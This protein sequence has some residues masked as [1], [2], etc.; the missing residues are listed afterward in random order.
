MYT[1][2]VTQQRTPNG[3]GKLSYRHCPLPY[4]LFVYDVDAGLDVGEGMRGGE[5]GLPFELLVEV[6]VCTAVQREGRAVDKASQVVVL[7][8][9]GDAVLHL[10]RVEE[11][12][13]VRDLNVSL[14]K[15]LKNVKGPIL[16]HQVLV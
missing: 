1:V 8:E 2:G 11:G 7:V 9:V 6:A 15:S 10:V 12:L 4:L 14:R 3:D 5:D 13:H 16:Y